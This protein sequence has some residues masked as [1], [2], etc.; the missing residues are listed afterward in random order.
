MLVA[1]SLLPSAVIIPLIMSVSFLD[2]SIGAGNFVP[3]LQFHPLHPPGSFWEW[4][5]EM[6]SKTAVGQ[7]RGYMLG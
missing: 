5:T 4:P 6:M 7:R 1:F 3:A 2:P